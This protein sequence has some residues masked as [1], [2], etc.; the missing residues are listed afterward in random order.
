MQCIDI[1][2][3]FVE[4]GPYVDWDRQTDSFKIGDPEREVYSIATVWKPTFPALREAHERGA[5][6]V[7]AHESLFIK[8]GAG[9]EEDCALP[10]EQEKLDWLRETGLVVYRCHDLWDRFPDIGIRWSWHKGLEL[11]GRVIADRF[12]HLVTEIEPVTLRKLAGHILERTRNLGQTSVAVVGDLDRNVSKV[13]TGTG[14]TPDPIDL[15][16]KG[17]DV[18]VMTDDY[19]LYCREGAHAIEKGF[20]MIV[21]NHGVAEEWGIRNL[22]KYLPQ[23]FPQLQVFHVAQQ[24]PYKTLG[25]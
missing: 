3:H 25:R 20:P 2:R 16:K 24:C 12:P 21:V 1:H 13:A 23:Q 10:S 11:G 9:S 7:V 17:A 14:V 15:W 18:G 5:E 4:V 19:F 6:M 22:A 8:G